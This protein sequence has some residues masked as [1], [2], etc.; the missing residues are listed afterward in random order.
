MK[1][2]IKNGADAPFDLWYGLIVYCFRLQDPHAVLLQVP[3]LLAGPATLRPS[4]EA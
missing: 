3:Q 2:G 4:L 1:W